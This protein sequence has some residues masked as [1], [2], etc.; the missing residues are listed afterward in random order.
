MMGASPPL[1]VVE[2]LKKYFVVR[3]KG[4]KRG[5]STVQAV[6]DVSFSIDEG[7]T[8]GLVGESGCG[9]TTVGRT[10]LRLYTP[11]SGHVY[12][13]IGAATTDISSLSQGKLKS[14]RRQMQIVYQ[15][16][17]SSL[18]PRMTIGS[19]LEEPMIVHGT[20]SKDERKARV[21]SILEAVGMKAE[22]VRRYPHEFSGGQRQRIA[23]ARSLV[24]HPRLVVADEPVSSLDVSIQAQ[25]LN[26]LE[27][28]QKE[29]GLTYLFIAHNLSVVK[30]ISDRIAVMYLGKIV[31]MART[32]SLFERPRH[33]YTEALMSAIPVPDP[34]L[35]M[36]RIA[37]QGDVPSPIN[38]PTGCR[39]HPRCKY[40]QARCAAE[41]PQLRDTGNGHFA[42]CHFTETLTLDSVLS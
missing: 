12:F 2:N 36:H 25:V 28:L 9:K 26:L 15:D 18:D 5:K 1:L 34:D 30:H 6:D 17:Y 35:K 32:E 37:L 29:L 13:R 31:E 40:A 14:I 22:H 16:P 7:E 42:A 10:V 19:L 11:T 41:E 27:D 33:P 21:L 20:R 4:P 24:L 3:K 23:I 38:P 8:L 39:F